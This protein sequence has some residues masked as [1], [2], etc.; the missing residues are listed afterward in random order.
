MVSYLLGIDVGTTSTRA[1]LIDEQGGVI[2][3]HAVEYPLLTPRPNW[4]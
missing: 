2:A 4:A 1:L 3:S